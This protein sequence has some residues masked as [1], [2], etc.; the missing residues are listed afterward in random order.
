MPLTERERHT[1]DNYDVAAEDWLAH[2]G[3][4]DRA[5]FWAEEMQKLVNELPGQKYV[6][7]VG[8]GPAT[9][10]KYLTEKGAKVLSTDYTNSMLQIAKELNPKGV[11]SQMDMTDLGLPADTFDGFWATA[12]LLHLENPDKAL[13]ELTRVTKR[14]GAGFISIKEGDGEY[15]DPRTGYYFRYY[16]NPGFILKLRDMGLEVISSGRKAGSPNHDFLTYLVKV[17]K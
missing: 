1:V 15:V 13:G 4:R 6:L 5:C 2:S 14:G 11:Y 16:R 10:G 17:V 8:C 3:G 12:C 9:D 7:E